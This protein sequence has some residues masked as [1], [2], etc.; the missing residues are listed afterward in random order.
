MLEIIFNN[1]IPGLKKNNL[2]LIDE[3]FCW[4]D[5]AEKKSNYDAYVKRIEKETEIR[6]WYSNSQLGL[7]GFYWLCKLLTDISYGGN[8]YVEN[9]SKEIDGEQWSLDTEDVLRVENTRNLLSPETIKENSVKWQKL[10]FENSDVRIIKNNELVSDI[11]DNENE[12]TETELI[13]LRIMKDL[14][15]TVEKSK[16][17]ALIIGTLLERYPKILNN[18]FAIFMIIK[19]LSEKNN[20][21]IELIPVSR[22][23][24]DSNDYLYFK[25]KFSEL[26]YS[27]V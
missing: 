10:C 9:S 19:R 24:K 1:V 2:L 13:V 11:P 6:V 22:R 8:V 17:V 5:I 20:P 26:G 3:V 4:G 7:S 25:C 15:I 12:L 18:D 27:I 21:L 16:D 23:I 14:E